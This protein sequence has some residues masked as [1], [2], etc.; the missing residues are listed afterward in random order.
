MTPKHLI[1]VSTQHLLAA[2]A[3]RLHERGNKPQIPTAVSPTVLR[4]TVHRRLGWLR[5]EV[6]DGELGHVPDDLAVREVEAGLAVTDRAREGDHREG[7]RGAVGEFEV[8]YLVVHD[9][10]VAFVDAT[11]VWTRLEG[12]RDILDVRYAVDEWA[13]W[14]SSET[15]RDLVKID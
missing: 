7:D 4:R 2:S 12:H 15:I 10:V 5:P 13:D 1:D 11:P 14:P 9:V 6:G 3:D 8:D